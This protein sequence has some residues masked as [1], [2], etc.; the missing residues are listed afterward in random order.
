[1]KTEV[2][3][4]YGQGLFLFAKEE[5]KVEQFEQQAK[6]VLNVLAENTDLS[7]FLN[8]V[9]ITKDEKKALIQKVF[10]DQLD[11]SF[12]NFIKVLIDKGRID[13]IEGILEEYVSLT[14]QEMGIVR[15]T[16]YSA[17]TLKDEDLEKIKKALEVKTKKTIR[18]KNVIK[19]ALLA[20][21]QVK[22]ENQLIDISLQSQLDTLKQRLLKGGKA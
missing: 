20:G 7:V 17:R 15:A 4:N 22:Y 11:Q 13:E 18:L 21:I 9:K 19:P 12:I 2:C 3:K 16:V 8:A 10:Q 1:M 6:Q 14:E 5:Q